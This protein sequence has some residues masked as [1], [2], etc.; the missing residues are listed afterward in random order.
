LKEERQL[1]QI[2]SEKLEKLQEENNELLFKLGVGPSSEVPAR[3]EGRRTGKEV[4]TRRG[5]EKK[6]RKGDVREKSGRG[7]GVYTRLIF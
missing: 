5:G 2:L 6:E 1:T 7:R 3:D 4:V